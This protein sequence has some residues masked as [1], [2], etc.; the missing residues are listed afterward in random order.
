M[1]GPG[2]VSW[3][4]APTTT[5][6]LRLRAAEARDR[7]AFIELFSSPEV[8]AFIGGAQPRDTLERAVP[9]VPGRRPGLF[10][11]ALDGAMIGIVTLDRPAGEPAG[12]AEL[13]Y[14]FLPHAWG[15]GYAAE[16]REAALAWF[17]GAC[18]GEP[19][20]LR[21]R[22]ANDRALRLAVR[23]GFTEVR[24]YQEYGAEQWAGVRPPT[25]PP[26]AAR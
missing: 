1:T 7:A 11:A 20:A 17:A 2:P 15:H 16:A 10:V 22:T 5:A 23:L 14:L 19:V 4:P 21:T 18:P 8:G 13:G 6:R 9:E 24:R 12:R 26:R 3:P 25:A